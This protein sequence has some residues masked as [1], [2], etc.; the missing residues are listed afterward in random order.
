MTSHCI[1]S[2][3]SL[4]STSSNIQIVS[5]GGRTHSCTH[6]LRTIS[7]GT[8]GFTI[9]IFIHSLPRS[10][11]MTATVTVNTKTGSCWGARSN[12]GAAY[13]S[14]STDRWRLHE[15]LGPVTC[16]R[17]QHR[18]DK[19]E[20]SSQHQLPLPHG[21]LQRQ[22]HGTSEWVCQMSFTGLSSHTT[23]SSKHSVSVSVTCAAA[24]HP[25]PRGSRCNKRS[26]TCSLCRHWVHRSYY[27]L[28][29]LHHIHCT[30]KCP[31]T[32][33]IHWWLFGVNVAVVGL[34]HC[35]WYCHGLWPM[36]SRAWYT[37]PH[38]HRCAQIQTRGINAIVKLK[39]LLRLRHLHAPTMET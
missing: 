34:Q 12:R 35:H 17:R 26:H 38:P 1:H 13:L 7:I 23:S 30:D 25:E 27:R 5:G 18:Q 37:W 28:G 24:L 8:P 29:R 36:I 21:E 9:A 14:Q 3:G 32:V 15:L 33:P 11:D 4:S 22:T 16:V 2:S 31:V 20:K 19:A 6:L 39:M 10:T